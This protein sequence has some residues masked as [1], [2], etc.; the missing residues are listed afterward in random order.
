MRRRRGLAL[1]NGGRGEARKGELGRV[2]GEQGE[3]SGVDAILGAAAALGMT[4]RRRRARG[5]RAVTNV[6]FGLSR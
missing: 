2:G 1:H 6:S 5:G 3:S 4:W